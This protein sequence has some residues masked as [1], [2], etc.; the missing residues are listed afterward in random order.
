MIDDVFLLEDLIAAK[1]I[2]PLKNSV[3]KAVK[4]HKGDVVKKI[5]QKVKSTSSTKVT[6]ESKITLKNAGLDKTVLNHLIGH[7]IAKYRKQTAFSQ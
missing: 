1:A 3:T 4:Q 7:A 5:S 6:T 2:K